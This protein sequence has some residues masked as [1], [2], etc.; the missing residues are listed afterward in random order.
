MVILSKQKHRFRTIFFFEYWRKRV[1]LNF[2][3]SIIKFDKCAMCGFAP[4]QGSTYLLVWTWELTLVFVC[5]FVL[6]IVIIITRLGKFASGWCHLI[7]LLVMIV[8]CWRHLVRCMY[9]CNDTLVSI[10]KSNSANAA[11]TST[12]QDTGHTVIKWHRQAICSGK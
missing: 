9:I 1:T 5:L 4:I 8:V 10:I 11:N 7:C 6:N 3:K 2:W 12:T